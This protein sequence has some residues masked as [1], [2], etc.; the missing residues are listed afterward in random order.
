MQAN[1]K[2]RRAPGAGHLFVRTTDAG[3]ENWY[4][5]WRAGGRQVL[6]KVGPKRTANGHGLTRRQA[7]AKLR[8]MIADVPPPA[9]SRVGL[10][11][12]G[13]A[14]I[15]HLEALG[16]K[17]ATIEAYES[18]LRVHLVPYFAG[19]SL[20][21][22]DGD[23]IEAF[24]RARA[25][26][27]KSPKTIRNVLG[28][29][30][31]IY[32]FAIKRGW[33]KSNPTKRIDQPAA[34]DD[35]DIRFLDRD[36]LAA[37]IRAEAVADDDLAPILAAMYAAAAMTRLRQGELIALRWRDIDWTAGRVRVRRAYVRGEYGTPKSRRGSRAVPL[38]DELGAD[39]DR[40]YKAS[41]WQGDDDL[42]FAHPV[43]GRPLDRAK[44]R[45][46]FKAA[47]KAA[48]VGRFAEVVRADG[49]T[50]VRALTR[51]HDLRHSF[52]TS[53]AGVGVPMRTL[54]EW[55]GHRDSK[56][57]EIYADYA[58]SEHERG[59]IEAA[60]GGARDTTGDTKPTETDRTDAT[61][62]RM[63]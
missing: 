25:R 10:A 50:E 48:G 28:L 46:R 9:D 42:V 63:K 21:A 3:A 18:L 5:K 59:W 14:L 44:V 37:V 2:T 49:K 45:K 34:A 26:D 39:L 62:D 16:R 12:A 20:D 40:H 41:R 53:M 36:E 54:Q 13:A 17:P 51:F 38:A 52:G 31:S 32:E 6:R 22:I 58:P 19:R 27:G 56:T 57:T 30:H 4:G 60:F 47:V 33:A 55:M 15:A 24:M 23:A 11:E 35:A 1:R 29:L 43:S 7:E 8:A 61:Q